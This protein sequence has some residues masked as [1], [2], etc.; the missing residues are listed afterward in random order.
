MICAIEIEMGKTLIPMWITYAMV[1]GLFGALSGAVGKLSVSAEHDLGV[2]LRVALFGFNGVCTAQMW[3]Y[4]LR[5]L[6][7]GPTPVCQILNTGMNFAVSAL[8]GIA[9]FAESVSG[10]WLLGASCV[11]LG[12]ALV[13]MD[14]GV[15]SPC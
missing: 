5:A 4:H 2:Y 3:R 12:M 11:A 9:F 6:S 1:A 10:M 14:P 8:V 7:Q 13:V 15:A